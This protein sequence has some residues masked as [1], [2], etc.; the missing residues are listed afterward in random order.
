MHPSHGY[1]AE[2]AAET[3]AFTVRARKQLAD[4]IEALYKEHYRDLRVYLLLSGCSTRDAEEFL[5]DAFLRLVRLLR[6][7]K[8]IENP[9]HWLLRVLHNIR[10]DERLRTSRLVALEKSDV[11]EILS[12]RA[13][14][15]LTPE[16]ALLEAE[17]MEQL[18]IAMGQLTDRQRECLLLR[19]EGLKL[20]EIA[21]LLGIA[22][23]S[24]AEACGRAMDKLGRL[25]H[26]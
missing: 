25:Q 15:G 20:R 16:A 22:T 14:G 19:A 18:R 10:S 6:G 23:A 8:S 7:G 11:A 24:V 17:R 2:L 13:T 9:K 26:E 3:G 4:V 21:E 1:G 5:Q 12:R